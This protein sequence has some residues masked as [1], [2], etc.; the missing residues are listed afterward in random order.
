ML[1]GLPGTTSTTY[2]AQ[3]TALQSLVGA[4]GGVASLVKNLQGVGL[5]GTAINDFI[6]GLKGPSSNSNNT[7][8]DTSTG[9]NVGG[10]IMQYTPATG[11]GTNG[12]PGVGQVLGQDGKVYNDPSYAAGVQSLAPPGVTIGLGGI[13]SDGVDYGS[14]YEQ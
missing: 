6:N 4:S 13:G 7:P 1:Q 2:G 3:P 5:T 12:T 11:T 9:V 8:I 10:Q 14:L